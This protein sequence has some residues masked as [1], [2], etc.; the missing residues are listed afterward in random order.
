MTDSDKSGE[1]A[2]DKASEKAGGGLN[3]SGAEYLRLAL[4]GNMN[5]L[6]LTPLAISELMDQYAGY[7]GRAPQQAAGD[8][9][10]YNELIYAVETKHKD[11]SRHET[12]LRYITEAENKTATAGED[13]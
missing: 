5:T 4:G 3:M 13:K 9:T 12:A 10:P 6:T 1:I 2:S 11:E 8:M 7:I